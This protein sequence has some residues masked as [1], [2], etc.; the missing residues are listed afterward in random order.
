MSCR[1]LKGSAPLPAHYQSLVRNVTTV[2][3]VM[4][5]FRALLIAVMFVAHTEGCAAAVF[6]AYMMNLNVL[7]NLDGI[8]AMRL[9]QSTSLG[10][11]LDI[12]LDICSEGLLL[13]CIYA[14]LST[15]ANGPSHLQ[16]SLLWACVALDRCS[17][18]V[19]CFGCI[20]IT[21]AGS[22]W[23]DVKYPCPVTRWYYETYLG[24]YGLYIGYHTFL[25]AL[26][27]L[28]HGVPASGFLCAICAPTFILRWWTG[29][30]G[31]YQVSKIMMELDAKNHEDSLKVIDN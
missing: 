9:G 6:A 17:Y 28:S 10:R 3:N 24:G 15:S 14:S 29:L 7:D 23:K 2:P 13:C 22:C 20:A 21:F 8:V 31:N 5:Y 1:T 30:V 12:G 19:G 18:V 4:G 26:Y 27:L 11:V 16:S 25:A